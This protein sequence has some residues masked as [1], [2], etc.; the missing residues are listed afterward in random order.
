[1]AAQAITL[2]AVHEELPPAL[3][4][5]KRAGQ[6]LRHTLKRKCEAVRSA[7]VDVLKIEPGPLSLALG[8]RGLI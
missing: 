1:M 7:R 2:L 3:S 4:I 8:A 5:A 6:G